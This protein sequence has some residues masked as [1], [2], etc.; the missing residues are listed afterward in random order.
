ME[1]IIITHCPLNSIPEDIFKMAKDDAKLVKA[2]Q[3]YGDRLK[4]RDVEIFENRQNIIVTDKGFYLAFYE[5]DLE[6]A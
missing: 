2:I 6:C 1:E 4:E 3:E 5:S